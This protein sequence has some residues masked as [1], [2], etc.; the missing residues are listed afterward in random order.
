VAHLAALRAFGGRPPVHT[1]VLIEGS[2]ENGRQ[3]LLEVVDRDPDLMRAD[4]MVIADNGNWRVG[5]PT[6]S[7]TLRGHGK[8]TVT[9]RTLRNA[10]HSGHFGGG[11]PDALLALTRLI[12]TL[13]HDDGSVAVEG[14]QDGEWAGTEWPE[15]DFRRQAGVLDGVQ[16]VGSGKLSD[17]VWARHAISV[18]GLDAP[19]V[20]GAGNIV[21]PHAR[22]KIAVR[23]PP[24]ADPERSMA[25]VEEHIRA[26]APWGAHLDVAVEPA[27][28]PISLPAHP[29]AER[30]LE[31]AYGKP[32]AR[33]GSGGSVPLVAKLNAAY[34]DASIVLW[35]AQDSDLAR[36]H[37]A[38]ESVDL[39]EIEKIARAEAY[40]LEEL[41]R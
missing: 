41:G 24:G 33:M 4:V 11:A 34:P 10:L 37:A 27:S 5:E 21:I 2:E 6:L 28:T 8:L 36:I 18:L 19:S 16:L 9:V 14:L 1:K 40:L 15:E 22:A 7:E 23:V 32:V 17:R 29:A 30:A 38:N 26:H 20:D 35:G 31:R 3:A 39:G 12:A 25:L 13:H